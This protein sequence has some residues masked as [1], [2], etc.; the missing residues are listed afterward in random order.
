M[1]TVEKMYGVVNYTEKNAVKCS[2]W[3][4]CFFIWSQK[5]SV[6]NTCIK[7]DFTYLLYTAYNFV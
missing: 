1:Y 4:F 2:F 7:Y 3:K 5:I 6:L